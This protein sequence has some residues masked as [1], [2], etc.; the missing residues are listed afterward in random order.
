MRRLPSPNLIK[1]HYVY[2][3]WEAAQALGRHRQT[4]VRWIKDKGLIDVGKSQYALYLTI[5]YQW[6]SQY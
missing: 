5:F 3:V 2:T 6:E 4:V 1:T